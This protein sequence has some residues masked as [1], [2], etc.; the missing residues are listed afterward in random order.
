MPH[1][2]A[3]HNAEH[4]AELQF[5]RFLI[6]VA[7]HL[8]GFAAVLSS[9]FSRSS[10]NRSACLTDTFCPEVPQPTEKSVS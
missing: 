2:D 10:A 6:S 7:R 3:Y 8:S 4:G 9:V 1:R 5:S